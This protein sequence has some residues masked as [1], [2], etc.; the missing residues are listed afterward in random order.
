[1]LSRLSWR[2]AAVSSPIR[3]RSS[4]APPAS[5]GGL[6]T[7]DPITIYPPLD[8]SARSLAM[9][10]ATKAA[11]LF[12]I[13]LRV[14][15]YRGQFHAEFGRQRL[16]RNPAELGRPIERL[17][18][19]QVRQFWRY[20]RQHPAG[21]QIRGVANR[22]VM[23]ACEQKMLGRGRI[24]RV[25]DSGSQRHFPPSLSCATNCTCA[26][27]PLPRPAITSRYSASPHNKAGKDQQSRHRRSYG[28]IG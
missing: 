7:P 5:T 25:R 10:A 23:K 13:R 2:P 4:N 1:M 6:T 18:S 26:A 21:D 16:R 24:V 9:E 12:V 22:A 3:P 28:V 19:V 8:E 17:S 14:D 27:T 20:L 15:E 11:A